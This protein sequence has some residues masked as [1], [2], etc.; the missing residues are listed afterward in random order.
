MHKRKTYFA[1]AM[2]K[3]LEEEMCRARK[4]EEHTKNRDY[5]VQSL[6]T[7]SVIIIKFLFFAFAFFRRVIIFMTLLNHK[8]CIRDMQ[9]YV[10]IILF[11]SNDE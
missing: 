10:L 2:E 3:L 6:L 4:W 8:Y 1:V 11:H 9:Y 5:T 7:L